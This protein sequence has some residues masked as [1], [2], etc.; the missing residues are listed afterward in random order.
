[1]DD[2]DSQWMLWRVVM[3]F[4]LILI[5]GF[6]TMSE[7]AIIELNDAR[8]RKSAAEGNRKAEQLVKLISE[9]TRFLSTLQIGAS[10]SGFFAAALVADSFAGQLAAALETLTPRLSPALCH[11]IS[12]VSLTLLL[13]YFL[14]LFG[15]LAPT[16]LAKSR[17]EKIAT[18]VVG[19]ISFLAKF[20][21][22]PVALLSGSTGMLLRLLGVDPELLPEA[23]TEEDIR[24]LIDAGEESGSIEESDKDMINNIFELDDRTVEEMMSHRTEIVAVA[25][26]TPLGEIIDTAVESGYSRIPVYEGDVDTIRGILYVKDFLKLLRQNPGAPFDLSAHMREP[27]YVLESM[28]CKK[29]LAEFQAKKLQMAVVIDE[30]G[31][32]SGLVTME[33]LL[34]AIVGSIQDEYDDEEAEIADL[35][36]DTFLLDGLADLEEAA[37]RLGMELSADADEFETI[38]G[39][40]IHRLG[41]LPA[42]GERP[43]LTEHGILFTVERMEDRRIAKLRAVRLAKEEEPAL[44]E[45]EHTEK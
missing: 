43:Q 38:G 3:I 22:P 28:S 31:G 5:N 39:Y 27:F 1:M 19:P 34:E 23:V 26:G 36:N 33:D 37:K 12:L 11:A 24:I 15:S 40:I 14:L 4:A 32:T 9:P 41:Y 25:L 45:S 29:L 2:P 30:Y 16:R 17:A 42:E 44:A 20:L 35:D 7:K 8:L 13:A 6:F 18:A 21:A 10:L